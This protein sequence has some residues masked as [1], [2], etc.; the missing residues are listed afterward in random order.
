MLDIGE[1][2]DVRARVLS[3]DCKDCWRQNCRGE[4]WYGAHYLDADGEARRRLEA[5]L[6][7]MEHPLC[8]ER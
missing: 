5:Q 3:H 4:T 6:R 1:S 7:E 8:G 2:D